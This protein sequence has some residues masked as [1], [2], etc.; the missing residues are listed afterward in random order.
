MGYRLVYGLRKV[1]TLPAVRILQSVSELPPLT[2]QGLQPTKA[3]LARLPADGVTPRPS[4]EAAP[5]LP[6]CSSLG[7]TVVERLWP[8]Q[9]S[10]LNTATHTQ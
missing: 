1:L 6:C 4:S 2:T 8:H 10:G 9:P 3:L 5:L 7:F